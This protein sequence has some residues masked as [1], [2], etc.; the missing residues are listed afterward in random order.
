MQQYRNL[1]LGFMLIITL[2]TGLGGFSLYHLN[3]ISKDVNN[4][5]NH[6][7]AVSNAGQSIQTLIFAMHRDMKDVVLVKDAQQVRM[8][9]DQVNR[10]EEEALKEF[11]IIFERF[12]GD[13]AAI[14]STYQTFIKWKPI[15]DEVAKLALAGQY[16]EAAEI[17]RKEGAQHIDRLLSEVHTFVDFAQNK[18]DEFHK[19]SAKNRNQSI[20]VVTAISL[21]A[22]I[23]AL[24]IAFNVTR[25]IL[26]SN[27]TLA[28]RE[29]LVDQN[30]MFANLDR[31]GVVVD[32]S[33]ALCRFLDTTKDEVVGQ[34]SHFFDNSDNQG[35]LSEQIWRTI[36]TGKSWQGEVRYINKD[37]L[38]YW[39]SSRVLPILDESYQIT[40]YTNLLQD[41]TSKKLSVTDKLTTLPNRRSFE[42]VLER[43]IKLSYRN[44]T[45]MALAILDVDFFK[46]YN[47]TYGH[48]QGDKA[49]RMI[50]DC[51]LDCL[52]R[53]SDYAFRIGGEEFAIITTEQNGVKAQHFL[54]H[55]RQ[56]I[57]ALK[58]PHEKSKVSEFVTISIGA[59]WTGGNQISDKDE[60]YTEADK[61]LY[62]AKVNRNEL[63]IHNVTNQHEYPKAI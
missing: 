23:S 52:K 58:I 22:V 25:L 11:N 54:D 36:K 6:P 42:D 51:I 1:L 41:S 61:A 26:R 7:F 34:P 21:V 31:N 35:L 19:Q 29:H 53:P 5:Y 40:G 24:L 39:A 32:A 56:A 10:Q 20:Y 43:E 57:E 62:L 28:Q 14:Q 16:N 8:I 45:S 30:I 60:L 63:V 17:T 3:I 12:L 27:K 49:L 33:N 37:G 2:M 46:L 38:M 48:P 18:A 55:I 44:G 4:I 59:Y 50:A 15:R 9:L 47:D 13:K